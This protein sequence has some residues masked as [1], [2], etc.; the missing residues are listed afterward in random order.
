MI[1]TRR[2]CIAVVG[3]MGVQL[4]ATT[5]DDGAKAVRAFLTTWL[6]N[7]DLEAGLKQVSKRRLICTPALDSA[8]TTMRPRAEAKA[9]LKTVM[10][11][12]NRKLGRRKNLA[13][14]ISPLPVELR[15]RMGISD[16]SQPVEFTLIDGSSSHV[17]SAMCG[18]QIIATKGTTVVAAFMFKVSEDETEGMYFAFQREGAKWAL[19][20]FDRLKQ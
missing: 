2:L 20:S 3:I 16:D 7:Q 14:A 17:K 10:E 5:R 13:D 15:S 1:V 19:V 9:T 12:V 6:I 4:V 11:I 8:E 18:G